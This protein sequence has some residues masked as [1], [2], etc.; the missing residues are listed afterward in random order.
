MKGTKSHPEKVKHSA[1]D[2]V[3]IARKFGEECVKIQQD[4]KLSLDKKLEK[5]RI[6]G[7]EMVKTIKQDAYLTEEDK[8]QM[9][10][11][12]HNYIEEWKAVHDVLKEGV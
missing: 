9:V 3:L 8:S 4:S 6:L 7:D 12:I 11:S 1:E 5:Q 2:W 10:K